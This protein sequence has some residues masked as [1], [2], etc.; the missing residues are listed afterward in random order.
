MSD[1]EKRIADAERAVVELCRRYEMSPELIE[2]GDTPGHAFHGNQY[3]G[4]GD[5]DPNDVHH[6][7][8]AHFETSPQGDN[9][10]EADHLKGVDAV[11]ALLR[12]ADG[13]PDAADLHQAAKEM[14]SIFAEDPDATVGMIHSQAQEVYRDDT[15]NMSETEV[16]DSYNYADALDTVASVYGNAAGIPEMQ[17]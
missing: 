15:K 11:G 3:G 17:F 5:E 2:F 8:D 12:D 9:I 1:L 7:A 6:P 16:D 14:W 4:G 10:S 13:Q